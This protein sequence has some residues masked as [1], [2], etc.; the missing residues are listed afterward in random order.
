MLNQGEK[1]ENG[2][3]KEDR[4]LFFQRLQTTVSSNHCPSYEKN[5]PVPFPGPKSLSLL[6]LNLRVLPLNSPVCSH[7]RPVWGPPLRALGL[8]VRQHP[9]AQ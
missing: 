9:L 6:P 7:P 2:E 1:F 4:L 5:S 8:P 3:E